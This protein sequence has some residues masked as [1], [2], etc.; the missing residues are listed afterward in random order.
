MPTSTNA[1]GETRHDRTDVRFEAEVGPD[2]RIE[3]LTELTADGGRRSVRPLSRE[4]IAVL[5]RGVRV[6]YRFDE[7]RRLRDLPYLDLL[8]AMRQDVLLTAHKAR[9]GELLDEPDALP[10]LKGLLVRIESAAEA[11]RRAS[12]APTTDE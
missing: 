9:H 10:I 6:E 11:F 5:T 7:G 3:V 2:G 4:A 12:E 1:D 8:Q